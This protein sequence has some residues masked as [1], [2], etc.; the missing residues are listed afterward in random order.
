MACRPLVVPGARLRPGAPGRPRE[1]LPPPLRRVSQGR[2][3]PAAGLSGRHPCRG[4]VG[5]PSG[6]PPPRYGER[7]PH[8]QRLPPFAHRDPGSRRGRPPGRREPAE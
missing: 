8:P 3:R 4:R 1:G 5:D 2:P 6:L 7:H